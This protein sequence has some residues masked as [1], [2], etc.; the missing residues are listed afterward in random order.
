MPHQKDFRCGILYYLT[1]TYLG[2][3]NKNFKPPPG[4]FL[5]VI[6]PP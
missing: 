3:V 1:A 4:T 6:V 5:A 2:N